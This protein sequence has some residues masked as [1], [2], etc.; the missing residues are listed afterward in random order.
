MS[1]QRHWAAALLDAQQGTP[2]GLVTWNGSDPGR[3]FAVYRNNV[4]VSLV[5]ALAQTFAVTQALVGEPFFRA[6][7]REFVLGAPPR[8]PVLAY[9]GREFPA[10]IAQFA[11]AAVVPYLAEVARLEMAY[12]EAFHG[13]DASPVSPQQLAAVL[14]DPERLPGLRLRLH[15]C[16]LVLRSPFA[17][18]SL[19]A[20]HQGQGDIAAV[21]PAQPENAWVLRR[22]LSVQVLRMR[23]GDCRLVESLAAGLPLGLAVS[24]AL[25]DEP[26]FELSRCLGVLLREQAISGLEQEGENHDDHQ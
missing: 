14:A 21:D 10:F 26:E 25:F 15:P 3:R 17:I 20:A 8:S 4:M 11:P 5:D 19:W 9:Y 12:V 6:M 18:V 1:E 16:L 22:D 24:A 13:P 23:P 7:A 2:A